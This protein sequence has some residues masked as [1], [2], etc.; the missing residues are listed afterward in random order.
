VDIGSREWWEGVL[1]R[2]YVFVLVKDADLNE[3]VLMVPMLGG[4]RREEEVEYYY[5]GA[6][7]VVVFVQSK[8]AMRCWRATFVVE[9]GKIL[10][11][12][13]YEGS[14]RFVRLRRGFSWLWS[15]GVRLFGCLHLIL[16][17]RR[18]SGR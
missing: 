4:G 17:C 7:S 12:V 1:R 3:V 9:S 14:M 6:G 16:S 8:E 18:F 13:E 2:L 5:M 15:V 10:R 11:P